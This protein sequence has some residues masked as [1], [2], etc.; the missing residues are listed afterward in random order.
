MHDL[1]QGNAMSRNEVARLIEEA[2]ECDLSHLI[3]EC[4][5]SRI[6]LLCLKP[7]EVN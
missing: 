1:L 5:E 4:R 3:R 7:N 6:Q 2:G